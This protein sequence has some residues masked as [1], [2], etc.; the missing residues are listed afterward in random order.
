MFLMQREL[1]LPEL[2]DNIAELKGSGNTYNYHFCCKSL[3]TRNKTV[4]ISHSQILSWKDFKRALKESGK[5]MEK[6][7]M[8]KLGLVDEK[9]TTMINKLCQTPIKG[10]IAHE[11]SEREIPED[12][13]GRNS[14]SGLGKRELD[15]LINIP[16]T[17]PINKSKRPYDKFMSNQ[18]R[19]IW[20]K[21][22]S[23]FTIQTIHHKMFEPVSPRASYLGQM[24][25]M[26]SIIVI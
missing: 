23:N 15:E 9:C 8:E 17:E 14:F 10:S 3:S 1:T 4:R 12:G 13:N 19:V 20:G 18:A 16:Y 5:P 25:A 6:A 7:L 24:I 11:T 21:V 2:L 22:A 26:L